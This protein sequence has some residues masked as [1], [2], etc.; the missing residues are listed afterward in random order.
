MSEPPRWPPRWKERPPED[1]DQADAAAL[2][3]ELR[4]VDPLQPEALARIERHVRAL[5]RVP[6]SAASAPAPRPP[7]PR[8]RL[9]WAAGTLAVAIVSGAGWVAL[10]RGPGLFG[11]SVDVLG[12]AVSRGA[13]VKSLRSFGG[14]EGSPMESANSPG[15]GEADVALPVI[16]RA[17][18]LAAS[19]R[20]REALS[21]FEALADGPAAPR[22]LIG[23]ARCE[24]SLGRRDAAAAAARAYLSRFPQGPAADEARALLAR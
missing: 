22:A 6:G 8:V 12:G 11:A 10:Q 16:D 3:E 14:G 13:Q 21:L 1:P 18:S 15:A 19:G 7:E 9:A 23:R 24:A 2:L 17:E 5:D 20:C 4:A